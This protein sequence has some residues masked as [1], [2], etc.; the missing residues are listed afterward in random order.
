VA[1]YHLSVKTVSRAAGRSA[2]AAAAYRAGAQITDERTGEIHDYTR[3]GGVE[4]AELVLPD[5]APEWAADRGQLWNAAEAAEKRKN[6]TVAREFEVALPAELSA[7]DRKQ[8]A[9]DFARELVERYRLVADVAIHAPGREGDNRNH[10]AHILCTTRSLEAEGFTAKTRELDDLK[11]GAVKEWRER[12]AD[13]TNAAL[14]RAGVAERIDH[15]SNAARGIEAEPSQHLGPA[16]TGIER[17]TGEPSRKREDFAQGVAERLEQ[18]KAAG[19]L[20]RAAEQTGRSIID[21][22]GDLSAALADRERRQIDARRAEQ[23]QAERQRIERMSADEVAAEIRRLRPDSPDVIVSRMPDVIEA[24]AQVEA[25]RK[26]AD[27]AAARAELAAQRAGEWREAHPIRAKLYDAGIRGFDELAKCERVGTESR[28]RAEVLRQSLP[29]RTGQAE[30]RAEQRRREVEASQREARAEVAKLAAL[31]I[32]KVSQEQ[33]EA[34]SQAQAERAANVVLLLVVRC[35]NGSE[36]G[37]PVL[38][39]LPE[40]VR[41]MVEHVRQQSEADGSNERAHRVLT[42]AFRE[43][44]QDGERIARE[45][46]RAQATGPKERETRAEPPTRSTGYDFDR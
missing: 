17:R 23:E 29:E 36:E 32:Q 44:P 5:G 43:R 40:G 12:W 15:R 35:Q 14:E 28:E 39:K 34:R 13:L 18:A 37:E 10:H 26:A 22:S 41:Q 2:T 38:R 42:Q 4:S 16:A 33:Q 30:A 31:H 9:H 21:L 1:I 25:Q 45:I 20:A 7:E 19:E 8:L 6:S 11:T 3:K 24:R 46:E 27:E